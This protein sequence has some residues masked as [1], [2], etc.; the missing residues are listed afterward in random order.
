MGAAVPAV[1]P[2]PLAC[3]HLAQLAGG[4][5]DEPGAAATLPRTPAMPGGGL[6]DV[7]A[8]ARAAFAGLTIDRVAA[9][10]RR[11]CPPAQQRMLRRQPQHPRTGI[12]SGL[13]QE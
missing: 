1:S 4:H 8:P 12:P 5:R 11:A 9:P 10:G 13:G 6:A 2:L 3:P 7:A